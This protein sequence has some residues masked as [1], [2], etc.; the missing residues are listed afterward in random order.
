MKRTIILTALAGT[1][2]LTGCG[3]STVSTDNI[4]STEV[5]ASK[6]TS[7]T[8]ISETTPATTTFS[9]RTESELPETK[10]QNDEEA[11]IKDL[12]GDGVVLLDKQYESGL[13]SRVVL[14]DNMLNTYFKL[15]EDTIEYKC[16]YM[17]QTISS[18]I[19]VADSNGYSSI[20]FHFAEQDS[21]QI[22]MYSINNYYGEWTQLIPILWHNDEYEE[23]WN[24]IMSGEI[25]KP[26]SEP[27]SVVIYDENE[28]T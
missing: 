9:E 26:E 8:T 22:A 14:K 10:S 28:N 16:M 6:E 27:E 4:S 24:K 18:M 2:L 25:S 1:I 5:T 11:Y 3:T 13:Y 21:T 19:D 17:M 23:V 20:T 15:P 7:A 12:L